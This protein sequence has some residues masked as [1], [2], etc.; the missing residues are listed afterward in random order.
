MKLQYY[1]V[2]YFV[3]LLEM[4]KKSASYTI[5]ED[6]LMAVVSVNADGRKARLTIVGKYTKPLSFPS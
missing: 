3:D 6:L 2:L 4:Q 1:I 5:V